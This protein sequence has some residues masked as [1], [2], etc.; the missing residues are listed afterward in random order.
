MKHG[1]AFLIAGAIHAI[2]S[3]VIIPFLFIGLGVQVP[4]KERQR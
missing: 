4:I 2:K 3:G 1:T